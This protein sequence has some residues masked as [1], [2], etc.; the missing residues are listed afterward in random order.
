MVIPPYIKP[1][2][3]K[4]FLLSFSVLEDVE[5]SWCDSLA[6]T[7]KKHNV[8]ATIFFSG[9]VADKNPECVKIFP[10]NV[11]IGSQT[12]HYVSLTSISDYT[13]KLE[14][15]QLGKK[16]VDAAGDL[17]SKLFK[18]PYGTTDDNIYSLLT[19]SN[20]IADFSYKDQYNKYYDGQFI[21]FELESYDGQT[22]TPEFFHNLITNEPIV[23]NFDSSVSVNY[24]DNFISKTK[25][26]SSYF[27][28]ASELTGLPLTIRNGGMI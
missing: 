15:I 12:Y 13:E 5:Q 3:A 27:I 21:T 26:H 7:I 17:N 2:S 22:H 23:I 18:A 16:A 9:K 10:Y 24:I 11:D 14:E 8:E 25:S 20:I 6:S 28:D 4:V 19:R 1:H